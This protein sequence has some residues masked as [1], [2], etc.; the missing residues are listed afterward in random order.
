MSRA[1]PEEEPRLSAAA[2]SAGA[3]VPAI[4]AAP[5]AT[6]LAVSRRLVFTRSIYLMASLRTDCSQGFRFSVRSHDAGAS[7]ARRHRCGSLRTD[8][9]AGARV[10]RPT[11]RDTERRDADNRE[12][13]GA[14]ED[15]VDT[16]RA[17]SN[18][19]HLLRS[20]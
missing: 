20:H 17:D 6:A 4:P 8:P 10:V 15:A 13:S 2:I 19:S 14:G 11:R 1:V 16:G 3:N 12:D 18:R 9:F 5:I 7:L